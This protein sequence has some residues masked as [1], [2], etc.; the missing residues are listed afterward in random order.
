[1]K[2]NMDVPRG[3]TQ[4]IRLRLSESDGS[5]RDYTE[6]DTVRFG[7]KSDANDDEFII[8]KTAVYDTEEKCYVVELAPED[9]ALLPFDRYWY[10]IGLQ[11]SDGEYFMLIEKS[12]F[13]LT[14][15]ITKKVDDT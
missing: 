6:A 5:E 11:T 12:E 8:S 14:R 3:T 2:L 10:D 1:M 13:N 7:V 15:A 9:T 4:L